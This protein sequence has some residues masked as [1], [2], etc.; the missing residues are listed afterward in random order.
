MN[1]D[2]KKQAHSFLVEK[3]CKSMAEN[4]PAYRIEQMLTEFAER[5]I[6]LFCQCNVSGQHEQLVKFSRFIQKYKNK[7]LDFDCVEREVDAYLTN[8]H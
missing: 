8:Y 6:K 5:Q 1:E 3:G 2:I 4:Y 7:G